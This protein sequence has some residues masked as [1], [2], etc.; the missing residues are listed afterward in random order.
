LAGAGAALAVSSKLTGLA[1]VPVAALVLWL[2]PIGKVATDWRTR[3]KSLLWFAAS[4]F[5]ALFLL[6]PALWSAPLDGLR[7]LGRA[8]QELLVAQTAALRVA[9]PGLVADGLGARAAGMLYQVYFA[10]LAFWDV[11]NYAAETRPSELAYLAQPLHS[12]WHTPVLAAN[13]LLGGVI[14]GLTLAGMAFGAL[15]L[16][17]RKQALRPEG[18]Y[19]LIVMGVWSAAT[20]AGLLTLNIIWQRYYLPLVPIACIW[21]AYGAASVA[22]PFVERFAARK[23]ADPQ[24]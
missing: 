11:P 10:P 7:A 14:F 13:M 19:S 15:S 16:L 6:S 4:F 9:T 22:R 23:S 21:A 8:R 3:L 24:S 12:G 18:S 5:A 1:L 20:V 2:A 17:R